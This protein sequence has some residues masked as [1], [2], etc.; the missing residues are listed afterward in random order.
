MLQAVY[1]A[2]DPTNAPEVYINPANAAQKL[3][4]EGNIYIL[5]DNKT[6]TINGQQV[7]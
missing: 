7:Q 1:E 3:I 6:Y 2:K 5:R 4:R